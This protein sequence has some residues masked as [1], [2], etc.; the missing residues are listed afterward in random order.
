M[1]ESGW[2]KSTR[3][4][5]QYQRITSSSVTIIVNNI[6]PTRL[7]LPKHLTKRLVGGWMDGLMDC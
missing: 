6:D 4:T 1:H 7:L 5:N 3:V 2:V